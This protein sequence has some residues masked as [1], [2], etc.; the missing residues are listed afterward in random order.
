[1]ACTQAYAAT[2][3]T[4]RA[5]T[6]SASIEECVGLGRA[7]LQRA[8]RAWPDRREGAAQSNRHAL[9]SLSQ[10]NIRKETTLGIH[11][12]V[13]FSRLLVR[14]ALDMLVFEASA[15]ALAW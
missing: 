1:M 12:I 9:K 8:M 5:E 4:R 3:K 2:I 13:E 7:L 15:L 6:H 11:G 14:F 10:Q